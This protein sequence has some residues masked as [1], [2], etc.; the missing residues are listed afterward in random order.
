M[1]CGEAVFSVFRFRQ[2]K[3]VK[4]ADQRSVRVD[5][6]AVFLVEEAFAVFWAFPHFVKVRCLVSSLAGEI[7]DSLLGICGYAFS[8]FLGEQNVPDF[9]LGVAAADSAVAALEA[10]VSGIAE[11]HWLFPTS[12]IAR[13]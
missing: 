1:C 2:F 3:R 4:P 13:V 10:H 9:F 5:G 11:V 8:V 7:A 12:A 6:A